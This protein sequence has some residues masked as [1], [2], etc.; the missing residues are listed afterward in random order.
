MHVHEMLAALLCD[1]AGFFK[2]PVT[3]CF[4]AFPAVVAGIMDCGKFMVDGLVDLDSSCF[5]IFL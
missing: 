1:P 5:N 2:I 4:L 3:E